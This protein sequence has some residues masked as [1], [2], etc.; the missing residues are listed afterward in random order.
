MDIEIVTAEMP[1]ES[2][3]DDLEAREWTDEFNM[4]FDFWRE[5]A[6]IVWYKLRGW[7]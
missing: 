1:E 2:D 7:I 6:A 3:R 5:L 4:Q